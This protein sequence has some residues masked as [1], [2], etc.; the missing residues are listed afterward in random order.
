MRRREAFKVYGLLF[1]L[2][3]SCSPS[4]VLGRVNPYT[5][6]LNRSPNVTCDFES[7]CSWKWSTDNFSNSSAAQLKEKL[8]NTYQPPATDADDKENGRIFKIF[9]RD[10]SRIFKMFENEPNIRI[11]LQ[12]YIIFKVEKKKGERRY[13]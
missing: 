9:I 10:D 5:R 12:N 1:L 11:R 7:N 13:V 2:I 8:G 4:R 6:M 3:A